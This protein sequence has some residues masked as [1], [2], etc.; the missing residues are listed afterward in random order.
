M[1]R[2]PITQPGVPVMP[3]WLASA[4]LALRNG[5]NTPVAIA[6]SA[7]ARSTP[8]S[9]RGLLDRL[10]VRRPEGVHRLVERGELAL[11]GR[12][13]RHA[14]GIDALRPQDRVFAHDDPQVG[15]G[16]DQL[17]NVGHALSAIGA[18]VVAEFDQRH[19]ALRIAEHG[20]GE[21]RFAAGSR[22]GASC[23]WRC[24]TW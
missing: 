7:G 9:S 18:G 17:L 13:E 4:T 8:A 21:R 10:L 19:L 5:S 3:I 23:A 20:A 14:R 15:I 22:T 1:I 12:G 6:L 16:G 11:L 2:S 24:C